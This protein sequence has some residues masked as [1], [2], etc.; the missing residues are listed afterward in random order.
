M[1][2][3]TIKNFIREFIFLTAAQTLSSGKHALAFPTKTP[4]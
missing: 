4:I 1:K 3:V 2:K